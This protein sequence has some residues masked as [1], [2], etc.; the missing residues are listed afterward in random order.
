MANT[1]VSSFLRRI[2]D[3]P[4]ILR[5]LLIICQPPSDHFRRLASWTSRH[6]SRASSRQYPKTH[7]QSPS[8][9]VWIGHCYDDANQFIDYQPSIG[10]GVGGRRLRRH[11]CP[12]DTEVGNRPV[13]F[14]HYGDDGRH[15][16]GISLGALIG[17]IV[18][19]VALGTCWPRNHFR[20]IFVPGRGVL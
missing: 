3:T 17:I 11:Q 20:S 16:V 8:I 12:A 6:P 2:Y 4:L 18:G 5:A 19:I 14:E 7:Q 13:T 1:T 9:M 10:I 15:C